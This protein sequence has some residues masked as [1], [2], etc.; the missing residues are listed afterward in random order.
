[1]LSDNFGVQI[2]TDNSLIWVLLDDRAGNRSQA[3]GVADAL[4]QSVQ[5][6]ELRYS[7][8]AKLPNFVLGASISGLTKQSKDHL[9]L[10]WPTLVISAGRRTAPVARWIKAQSGGRARLVQ[11][12]DPGSGRDD[13]DL[14]CMPAHDQ[15]HA[16]TNTLVISGAPH[17]I[18]A[19]K[20]ATAAADWS[21]KLSAVRAPRIALMIGGSTRRKTFTAA[22]A[23]DLCQRANTVASETKGSLLVTTSRRT[24][25]VVDTIAEELG[26]TAM[27]HRWDSD[28][29]NPYTGYL[30]LADAI[31]VTGESV[32]MCSE[33]CATGKP[34]YI[35]AP[36]DLI[37][38]KH[39]R[40]HQTLY[41]GGYA[42]P[43]DVG[44]DLAWR[45]NTLNVAADIASEI[46][47]RGLL[48]PVV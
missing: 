45:P 46:T 42:K 15:P 44:I 16:A 32:S 13:F 27:L 26:S 38:A 36:S 41:D 8:A 5:Q 31:V 25:D 1:M 47:S 6:K 2:L 39:G 34:A 10:P 48:R 24:G 37:T 20:L 18:T 12:M 43:F 30:A 14:I 9:E 3:L 4:E 35:F 17:G 23:Q 40:L 22:M 28:D 33:A 21:D 19:Q 11:I 29:E 7:A